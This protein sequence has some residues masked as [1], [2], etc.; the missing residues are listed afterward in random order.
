MFILFLV[1]FPSMVDDSSFAFFFFIAISNEAKDCTNKKR[2]KTKHLNFFSWFY[3][4][5]TSFNL[6]LKSVGRKLNFFYCFLSRCFTWFVRFFLLSIIFKVSI[7]I[8]K[9]TFFLLLKIDEKS[10]F[11]WTSLLF[12][13]V[14]FLIDI[15]KKKYKKIQMKLNTLSILFFFSFSFRF[16]SFGICDKNKT[17]Q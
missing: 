17:H 10:I 6:M 5:C 16:V 4:L 11:Y 8:D 2:Q 15:K 1:R 7:R 14:Y 3:L 12:R 9:R 13:S